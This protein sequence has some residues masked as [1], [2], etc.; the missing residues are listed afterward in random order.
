MKWV[1]V[2]TFR[3]HAMQDT[4]GDEVLAS[5]RHGQPIGFYIPIAASPQETFKQALERLQQTL[6]PVIAETGL[7]EMELSRLYD[8]KEPV[9]PQLRNAAN[10]V[11]ADDY[12]CGH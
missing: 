3:D 11:G 5:E 9:A 7:S 6:E 1:G 10:Q 2:R 8:L 4:V 12:T